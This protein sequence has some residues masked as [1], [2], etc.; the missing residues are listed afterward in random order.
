[1]D[2]FHE[3]ELVA[4][5]PPIYVLRVWIKA[6]TYAWIGNVGVQCLPNDAKV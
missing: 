1:M 4:L 6:C 2:K 5:A 3:L